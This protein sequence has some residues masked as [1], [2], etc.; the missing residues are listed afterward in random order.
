[1]KSIRTLQLHQLHSLKNQVWKITLASRA[2]SLQKIKRRKCD[3]IIRIW[4]FN[5]RSEK[6]SHEPSAQWIFCCLVNMATSFCLIQSCGVIYKTNT[7][8]IKTIFFQANFSSN[9]AIICTSGKILSISR[10]LLC[11]W[12]ASFSF[13]LF[14]WC[15]L[16][17]RKKHFARLSL[18]SNHIWR[19]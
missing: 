6:S 10:K 4:V 19:S 18:W 14:K 5:P 7:T 16:L 15:V 3:I 17:K 9:S 11:Y 1:M 12:K 2:S 8:F 13:P